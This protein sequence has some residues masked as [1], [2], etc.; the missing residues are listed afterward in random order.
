MCGGAVGRPVVAPPTTGAQLLERVER[1][2]ARGVVAQ[3]GAAAAINVL[4][5]VFGAVR[6]RAVEGGYVRVG[7]RRMF[8]ATIRRESEFEALLSATVRSFLIEC[9]VGGVLSLLF[10]STP[11]RIVRR[12]ALLMVRGKRELFSSLHRSVLRQRRRQR[13]QRTVS[14]ASNRSFII[15]RHSSVT[16]CFLRDFN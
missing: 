6:R 5:Q 1:G 16:S 4:S 9:T 14:K 13:L 3:L 12:V 15:L 10:A 2:G 7:F 8:S 11:Q